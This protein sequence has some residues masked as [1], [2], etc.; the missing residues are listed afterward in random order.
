MEECHIYEAFRRG[1]GTH[2][3]DEVLWCRD[4]TSFPGE[5]WSHPM[6]RGGNVI[7]A[8]V[9]F[10]NVTERKRAERVLREAREVA[11]AASRAKS[12]FLANMSHEIRTPINGIMGMTELALDTE[13]N[14]EQRDC[15]LLVKSSS[16]SL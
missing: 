5:Y 14:T 2:V 6:N 1:Q 7:G 9:T 13:L 11:E 12:E 15:L 4:G 10:V 8:V 16:E 3:D